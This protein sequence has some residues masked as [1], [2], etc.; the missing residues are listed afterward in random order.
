MELCEDKNYE[1]GNEAIEC[2]GDSGIQVITSKY[3]TPDYNPAN[4]CHF[5]GPCWGSTDLTTFAKVACDGQSSCIFRG[6]NGH[7]G[8]PCYGLH[9]STKTSFRC[10]LGN[11]IHL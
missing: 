7:A 10:A 8:D 6:N 9:K 3:G 11:T 5:H 2:P 1:T 4:S